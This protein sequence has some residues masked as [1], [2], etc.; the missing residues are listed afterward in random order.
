M[1]ERLRHVA[2]QGSIDALIQEDAN[3]LDIIDNISFVE[4]P[5]HMAVFEGHT[6]F[7][8]EIVKLKPSFARKLN[9]DGFSPMHLALQKLHELENNPDLLRNQS[10][11]VDRLLNVDSNIVRVLR[12][13][14]VTPFLYIA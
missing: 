8:T 12:R 14:R 3:V 9:Q 13:E 11:L 10:Q 7:A 5:L 6:W 2:K 1:D 4:T